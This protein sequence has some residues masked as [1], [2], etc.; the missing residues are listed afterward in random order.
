MLDYMLLAEI[1][2]EDVVEETF[3]GRHGKQVT[4]KQISIVYSF[5][6]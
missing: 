2:L 6:M 3:V 1:R 5:R 4:N